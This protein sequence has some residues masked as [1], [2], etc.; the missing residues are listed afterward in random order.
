MKFTLKH[1]SHQSSPSFG[2]LIKERIGSLSKIL[3]I[4]EARILVECRAELS[5][6]FRMAAQLVIPGPDLFAEASDHTLRAALQKLMKQ[7]EE[8]IDHRRQKRA[9]RLRES[10]QKTSAGRPSAVI[11]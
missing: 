9:K 11:R 2:A 3:R 8:R 7:L 10:P 6:P 5:P 4:D 1:Q